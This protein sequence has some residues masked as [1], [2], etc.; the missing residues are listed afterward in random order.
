MS[1]E[2]ATRAKQ[3]DGYCAPCGQQVKPDIKNGWGGMFGFLALLQFAAIV[4]AIVN[5]FRPFHVGG[6]I[7]AHLILW[8]AAIHPAWVGIIAVIAAFL[9]AARIST[10]YGEHAKKA[11]TCPKCHLPLASRR[12]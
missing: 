9:V 8:P 12:P 6:G 3:P 5:V 2:D 10:V 7:I 11:A 1:H 4:A